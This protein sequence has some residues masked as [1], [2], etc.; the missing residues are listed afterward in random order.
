MVL[1]TENA[2]LLYQKYWRIKTTCIISSCWSCETDRHIKSWISWQPVWYVVFYG[3]ISAWASVWC[4]VYRASLLRWQ[5]GKLYYFWSK[6]TMGCAAMGS[7]YGWTK[8]RK[9]SDLPVRTIHGC[10]FCADGIRTYTST[11]G[12]RP[13]CGLWFSVYGKADAWYGS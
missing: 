8:Q 7:I 9:A 10:S 6:G 13:D 5:R 1:W 11:G 4:P 2:G 3:E 12:E